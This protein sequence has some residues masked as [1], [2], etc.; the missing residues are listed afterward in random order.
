[1]S[2][3][4]WYKLEANNLTEKEINNIIK[5]EFS[6]K[7]EDAKERLTELKEIRLEL[8]NWIEIDVVKELIYS[9]I[10]GQFLS[11]IAICGVITEIIIENAL[12]NLTPEYEK[13]P[14]LNK[15]FKETL[16]K[17]CR[18]NLGF[19]GKKIGFLKK[20]QLKQ[21]I[22]TDINKLENVIAIRN[23][24]IH[25]KKL[26][27]ENKNAIENEKYK[28]ELKEDCKTCV[29][30]IKEVLHNYSPIDNRGVIADAVDN[31]NIKE[32]LF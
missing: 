3:V 23:K 19:I 22:L 24:Y 7:L 5:S 26:N 13:E 12:D 31:L 27:G 21:E 9:Y 17:H 18:E 10:N 32:K 30:L 15:E 1:M 11:A 6:V 4:Y 14:R 25:L 8:N 20:F 29:R 16:Y 28:I 2:L